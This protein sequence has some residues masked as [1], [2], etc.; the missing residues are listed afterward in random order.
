MIVPPRRKF[1]GGIIIVT[2]INRKQKLRRQYIQ[3]AVF[4]SV[5]GLF[6]A[7]AT[8]VYFSSPEIDWDTYMSYNN[9][10]ILCRR[11]GD[12]EQVVDGGWLK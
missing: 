7:F 5:I 1:R 8:A 9:A 12:L 11:M 2:N 10:V 4:C 3:M 6:A